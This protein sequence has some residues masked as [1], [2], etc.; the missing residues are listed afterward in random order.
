VKEACPI[1]EG[2]KQAVEKGEDGLLIAEKAVN[3]VKT[4]PLRVAIRTARDKIVELQAKAN[5]VVAGVEAQ[6][7]KRAE[8]ALSAAKSAKAKVIST[9]QQTVSQAQMKLESLRAQANQA[10]NGMQA[11][12]MNRAK[13]LADQANATLNAAQAAADAAESKVQG[14]LGQVQG[15]IDMVKANNFLAVNQVS[16]RVVALRARTSAEATVDLTVGTNSLKFTVNVDMSNPSGSLVNGMRGETLKELRRSLP[17]I[18][19]FIP[20]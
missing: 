14:V 18:A 1:A 17:A 4:G 9:A 16:L 10:A 3:A 6:A 5:A 15:A 2:L 11:Q 8:Q 20:G 13:M 19:N 12:A 7:K